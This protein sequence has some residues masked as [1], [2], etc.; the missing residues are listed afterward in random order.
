[1]GEESEVAEAQI[2]VHWQEG[3]KL[4]R[5]QLPRPLSAQEAAEV[6]VFGQAE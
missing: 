5:G 1:M 2:A 3:E 4:S 6:R